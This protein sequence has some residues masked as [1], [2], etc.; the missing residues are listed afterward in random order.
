MCNFRQYKRTTYDS[1]QKFGIWQ[2]FVLTSTGIAGGVFSA[3]TGS[4]LDICSFSML[5]L[6]FR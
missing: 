6:L 4:G 2:A 1:I 5:T 3:V